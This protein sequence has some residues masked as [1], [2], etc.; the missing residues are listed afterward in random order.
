MPAIGE[1][2][3]VAVETAIAGPLERGGHRIVDER[4]AADL[5]DR[6]REQRAA[7]LVAQ[8]VVGRA[9]DGEV[10]LP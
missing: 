1:G 8:A 9:A 10:A 2:I 6:R 3:E 4:R 7:R 5:A